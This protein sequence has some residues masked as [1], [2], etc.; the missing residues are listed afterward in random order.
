MATRHGSAQITFPSDTE[1]LITRSFEAPRSLVWE[2]M[3]TPRHVLRWWGPS[4]HPIIECHIDLR[5]GG[6]WRYTSRDSDGNELSWHGVYRTVEPPVRLVTTEVFE[7][8]PQ[9]EAVTTTTLDEHHGVT[10]VRTLVQHQNQQHRDGH[11][12]SGMEEGLQETYNRLDKLLSLADTPAE[13]FRRVAGRFADRIAE[14]PADA[15]SNPSPC[16]GWTARDVVD[17]LLTWVPS[18]I[19]RSGI[20]FPHDLLASED[21]ATAWEGFTTTLQTALDDPEV[22]QRAFDAGPPGTLTVEQAIDMLVTSDVLVHTWDLARATGL[23][24]R[25]D[26][27]V[28]AQMLAGLE[29]M[30]EVL[31]ASGHYGP[32]VIVAD[33]ADVQTRLLAFTGRQP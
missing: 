1:I 16:E 6:A 2:V 31:R 4:W 27:H 11:V 8:A 19:G 26:E 17:H 29:P 24:E 5:P 14:V 9:A 22:S 20:A 7:L 10:T 3:T 15:W 32:R 33:D 13:K 30:D 28:A 18:V 12:S 25:L 23:D 21:P